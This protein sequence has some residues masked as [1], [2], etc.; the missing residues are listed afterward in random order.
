MAYVLETIAVADQEKIISDAETRP[1]DRDSLIYARDHQLLVKTWAVNKDD[2]HYLFKAPKLVREDSEN[3][4]YFFYFK[5]K[6]YKFYI[7]GWFGNVAYL[8]EPLI[9]SVHV[10]PQLQEDVTRAFAVYGDLGSGP[11]NERGSAE[12][13]VAPMFKVIS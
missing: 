5:G 4:T 11:L 1:L 10:L 8:D 3:R 9:D 7:E 13:A 2:D 12:F 6:L